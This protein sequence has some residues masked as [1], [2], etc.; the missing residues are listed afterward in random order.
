MW[1]ERRDRA[2]VAAGLVSMPRFPKEARA[3]YQ[4]TVAFLK[5]GLST[6]SLRADESGEDNRTDSADDACT[7]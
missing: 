5:A 4:G 1:R 2:R 6:A 7:A 3:S